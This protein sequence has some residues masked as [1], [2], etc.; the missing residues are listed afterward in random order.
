MKMLLD[1]SVS[2]IE[3]RAQ[4]RQQQV[5]QTFERVVQKQQN[6]ILAFEMKYSNLIKERMDRI[7][8]FTDDLALEQARLASN[9]GANVVNQSE[10]A[11]HV[12]KEDSKLD[13]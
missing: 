12:I 11:N 1:T 7:E 2:E 13:E 6:T 9:S 5:T 3:K 8:A 10:L 4:L